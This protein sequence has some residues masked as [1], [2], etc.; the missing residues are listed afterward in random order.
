M[1]EITKTD[2]EKTRTDLDR[3]NKE[4]NAATCMRDNISFLIGWTKADNPEIAK[5]LEAIL[6]QH[7][8]NREQD[9]F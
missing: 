1:T 3:F 4:R 9:W 2:W 8:E 7:T 6:T 5:R